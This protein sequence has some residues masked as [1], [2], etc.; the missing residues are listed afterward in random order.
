MGLDLAD[1]MSGLAPH[2][3]GNPEP[4][5]VARSVQIL[6]FPRVV[7]R[8]HLRCKVRQSP[9]GTVFDVIG[10][11]LAAWLPVLDQAAAPLVDIAFTPERHSW[12]GRESLQLRVRDVRLSD[13]RVLTVSGAAVQQN[14]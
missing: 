11:N 12:N 14:G 2:G 3:I 9:S 5:L 1:A 6:R 4:L 7:G 13:P 8:K 10:F